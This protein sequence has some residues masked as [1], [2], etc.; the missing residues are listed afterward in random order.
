MEKDL[1]EVQVLQLFIEYLLPAEFF[2]WALVNL[3]NKSEKVL[4]LLFAFLWGVPA[5]LGLHN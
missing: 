3:M 4:V 2:C 5:K 1:E